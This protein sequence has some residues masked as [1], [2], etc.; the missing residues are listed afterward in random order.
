MARGRGRR[1]GWAGG[2]VE[3]VDEGGGEGRDGGRKP[4]AALVD[5]IVGLWVCLFV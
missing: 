4:P 1:E 5:I 3:D 2:W